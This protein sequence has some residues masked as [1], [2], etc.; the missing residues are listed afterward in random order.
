MF[1]L[2]IMTDRT[3]LPYSPVSRMVMGDDSMAAILC[4]VVREAIHDEQDLRVSTF[5]NYL[6]NVKIMLYCLQRTVSRYNPI[7]LSTTRSNK[8]CRDVTV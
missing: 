5:S 6:S 3:T 7:V 8:V 1:L 4:L 2:C